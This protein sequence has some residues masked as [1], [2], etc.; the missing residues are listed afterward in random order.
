MTTKT[1]NLN[2][3]VPEKEWDLLIEYC[4]KKKRTK[5]DVLREFIRSLKP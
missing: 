2:I 1:K 4:E 3:R 5:T